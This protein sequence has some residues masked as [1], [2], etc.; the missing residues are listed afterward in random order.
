MEEFTWFNESPGNYTRPV[1]ILK[2]NAFGLYDV[3]GNVAEITSDY[4]GPYPQGPVV[5]PTGWP[6][7]IP[8][9][10]YDYHVQGQ[11]I[12]GGSYFWGRSDIRSAARSFT[13]V[14]AH[15]TLPAVGFPSKDVGF[16]LV[17]QRL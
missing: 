5:D 1:G 17:R 6:P 15:P 16:R 2:P 10:T 9:D 14:S 7:C 13:W 11:V 12:R 3:Y 4:Y 8:Q